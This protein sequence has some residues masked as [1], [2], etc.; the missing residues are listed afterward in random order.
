MRQCLLPIKGTQNDQCGVK[1][2]SLQSSMNLAQFP[3]LSTR[4]SLNRSIVSFLRR[5]TKPVVQFSI[6]TTIHKPP[7]SAS[8]F[9]CIPANARARFKIIRVISLEHLNHQKKEGILLM[10]YYHSVTLQVRSN[11]LFR[12]KVCVHSILY[13]N[14][15][16]VP[17][18]VIKNGHI[19]VSQIRSGWCCPMNGL[20]QHIYKQMQS[21]SFK[22]VENIWKRWMLEIFDVFLC[23]CLSPIPS[24]QLSLHKG[25]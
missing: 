6:V 10:L 23:I 13:Q 24:I 14:H 19:Q 22:K 4:S 11:I 15:N 18:L 25:Q 20:V 7:S 2:S 5:V 21:C 9:A 1:W 16:H 3:M 12:G 17:M 8:F